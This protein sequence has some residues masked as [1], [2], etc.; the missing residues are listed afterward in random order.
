[1]YEDGGL[2]VLTEKC[3][4]ERGHCCGNKCRH[5]PYFPLNSRGATQLNPEIH[6]LQKGSSAQESDSSSSSSSGKMTST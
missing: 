4:L 5:C 2:V 1:M 3:L 6:A